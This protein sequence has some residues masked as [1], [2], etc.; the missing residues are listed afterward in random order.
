MVGRV[1]SRT[2]R[3]RQRVATDVELLKVVVRKDV[4]G[5]RRDAATHRAVELGIPEGK[6]AAVSCCWPVAL[7]SAVATI[8]V[9]WCV[10][11]RVVDK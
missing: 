8:S 10:R 9:M 4:I 5:R 1:T 11:V 6:V 3:L 7:L 2:K